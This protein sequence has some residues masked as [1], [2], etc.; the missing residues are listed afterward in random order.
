MF[1]RLEMFADFGPLVPAFRED[2]FEEGIVG[3]VLDPALPEP[4]D[5]GFV[6]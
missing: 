3:E 1:K 6:G 2:R 4:T 5:K